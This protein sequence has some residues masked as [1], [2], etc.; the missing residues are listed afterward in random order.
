[1]FSL[2]TLTGIIDFF[3]FDFLRPFEKRIRYLSDDAVPFPGASYPWKKFYG[4]R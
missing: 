4:R 1:M 3:H 2:A